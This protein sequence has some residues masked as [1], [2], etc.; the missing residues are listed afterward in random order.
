MAYCRLRSPAARRAKARPGGRQRC[1]KWLTDVA[2]IGVLQILK[3]T[4]TLTSAGKPGMKRNELMRTIPD[5]LPAIVP[6]VLYERAQRK[7]KTNR[8]DKSHLHRNPE[9][10]LLKGHVM[11]ATCGYAMVGRYRTSRHTHTY[12]YY[13]CASITRT[14]TW[15]VPI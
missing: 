5:G 12:P 8:A 13:A 3:Y 15:P 4:A 9:D 14:S 7:L 1:I 11:C 10:F 2:N 6:L